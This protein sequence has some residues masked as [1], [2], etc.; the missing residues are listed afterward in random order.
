MRLVVQAHPLRALHTHYPGHWG[1]QD[2]TGTAIPD[3]GTSYSHL[4]IVQSKDVTEGEKCPACEKGYFEKCVEELYSK[5]V[6]L[7]CSNCE[8]CVEPDNFAGQVLTEK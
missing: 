7:K 5:Y 8:V 6:Y 1:Y 3:S 4:V 2:R